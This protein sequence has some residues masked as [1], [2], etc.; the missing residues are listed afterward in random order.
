[1]YG[2]YVR[3][4]RQLVEASKRAA[5]EMASLKTR[6]AEKDAQLMGG[7]GDFSKFALDEMG[8]PPGVKPKPPVAVTPR[9]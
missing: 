9:G 5:K 3:V 8:P 4:P 6:L 1:M 2:S 7:F